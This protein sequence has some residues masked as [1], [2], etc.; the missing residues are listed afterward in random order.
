MILECTDIPQ[1]N[2]DDIIPLLLVHGDERLVTQDASI[3]NKNVNA[4]KGIKSSLDDSIAILSRGNCGDGLTT[5]LC[6]FFDDSV[7]TLGANIVHDNVGTEL[8]VHESIGTAEAPTCACDDDSLAVEADG[9][10]GL[11]VAWEAL[12]D[13]KSTLKKFISYRFQN[14]YEEVHTTMSLSAMLSGL[15]IQYIN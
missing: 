3:R 8:G 4:T 14:S 12:G 13:L 5:S 7:G 6:D 11:L 1:M 10:I 15:R 9:G 2:S